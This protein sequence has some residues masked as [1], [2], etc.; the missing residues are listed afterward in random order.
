MAFVYLSLLRLGVG[1]VC[2][3]ILL[4]LVKKTKSC[5]RLAYLP[6]LRFAGLSRLWILRGLMTDHFHATLTKIVVE[7]GPLARIG[8]NHLFTTDAEVWRRMCVARSSYRRSEWYSAMQFK[9]RPDNIIS[10]LDENVH[11][12]L[13]RK[14]AA[15]YAGKENPILEQSIDNQLQDLV[16]LIDRKYVSTD[17]DSEKYG[18]WEGSSILY[19]G[20]DIGYCL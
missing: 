15:E 7:Y 18:F 1:F 6:G 5:R 10:T 12:D 13:R 8:P 4:S 3:A 17:T 9:P 11:E 19:A 14:M 16:N 20:F 2:I